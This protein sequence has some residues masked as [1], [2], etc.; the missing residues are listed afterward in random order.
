MF[1]VMKISYKELQTNLT[2]DRLIEVVRQGLSRIDDP[3][4]KILQYS[5]HDL[6][7]S[8]YALF[9]L[10][11]PSLLRFE[12]QG[13]T[14]R[15]NLMTLFGIEKVC[16]DAQLRKVLDLIDP[17]PVRR[18]LTDLHSECH[19]LGVLREYKVFND[20]LICSIDGVHHYTSKEIHCE[21]C[22]EQHHRD[23]T[24]TYRHSM[25]CG[26][27]VHPE[28]REVFPVAMEAILKQDGSEK[29]D[30]EHNAAKRMIDWMSTM[31]KDQKWLIVEDALYSNGPHIEQI[32]ELGWAYIIGVKP[33]SHKTLFGLFESRKAMNAVH[34]HTNID[35]KTGI[36]QVFEWTLDM[37]LNQQQ[38][39]IRC[40]M[41]KYTE[42]QKNGDRKEF[43][44]ITNIKINKSQIFKIMKIG[45]SRWKIENETFN[46]L[47]NQGYHFEHNYGHGNKNLATE[48][49]YMM[50]I[51]FTT[52]QLFQACSQLFDR[53]CKK[54]KSRTYVWELVRA[55][56]MFR[57]V[58][59][60][61]EMHRLVAKEF[62]VQIE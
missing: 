12:T 28:H 39:H 53:L 62:F 43:S 61:H 32:E 27:I 52:D 26:A 17:N 57:P 60:Y 38:S 11:Y 7:M 4:S 6:I 41:L 30:C 35:S 46:T 31:Y 47:K 14:Q 29:N 9:L 15:T 19:R 48:M 2:M 56:F 59:T 54:L 50:V 16:S 33:G 37:P 1:A 18:L 45:R 44:W 3:R 42:I 51:A 49:A 22:M 34:S 23:G 36:Q 25:L 8:A 55:V 58:S 21:N 40:H 13:D 5:F 20:Y 10:K 24:V